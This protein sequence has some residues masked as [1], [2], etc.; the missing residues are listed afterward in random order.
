MEAIMLKVLNFIG[1]AFILGMV[2][3][4]LGGT[5]VITHRCVP[6]AVLGGTT[7]D[8]NI[9]WDNHNTE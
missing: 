1:L 2:A 8:D 4:T 6:T 7:C 3:I 5:K 9:D